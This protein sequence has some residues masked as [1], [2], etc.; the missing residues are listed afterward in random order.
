MR[1]RTVLKNTAYCDTVL[2]MTTTID[3]GE[4]ET[5][6]AVVQRGSFTAAADALETDKGRV[7]R[8]VT[9]LE[10]KLGARLLE[11][12]TRSLRVTEVGRDFFERSVSV[13]TAVE[14]TEAA[15]ARQLGKPSGTLKL[16]AGP[17]F[18]TLVVDR[19]VSA[20]LRQYPK[21]RVETEYTN[22]VTDIIHEGFD[23]AI[24][25]GPL[26]DS[27]LSA[28]KLIDLTYGL[29]AA[30][31]Y[32]KNAP[33]IATPDEL[34][35][36]DLIMFAPRGRAVWRLVNGRDSATVSRTARC[37]V[38]NNLSALAMAK[39]SLG[40]ALLPD[41]M[42][43]SALERGFLTRVLPGWARI[44]VPVHAVFTS[45]RYMA[46]KVRAFVDLAVAHNSLGKD[47]NSRLKR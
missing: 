38:N 37:A 36:H 1:H 27:D 15:I 42:A 22:R 35:A 33:A 21:V 8:S 29:Y 45:S 46:P 30:P 4:M 23:V 47:P 25:V 40:I 43:K 44:P 9:R 10:K 14:E 20:Y 41:F 26:S 5:F 11:R 31:S 34:K 2:S 39:A 7:S 17:E 3:L 6:V 19:W 32:L 24:R 16:T 18:G 12:S 13:L 28:R